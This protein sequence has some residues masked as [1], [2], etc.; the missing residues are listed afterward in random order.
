MTDDVDRQAIADHGDARHSSVEQRKHHRDDAKA[1]SEALEAEMKANADA[2]T[3]MAALLQRI[4]TAQE[5]ERARIARTLHDHVGQQLTALRLTLQS[6]E[7]R[8]KSGALDCEQLHQALSMTEKIDGDLDFLA[9]ELRPRALDDHGL[10]A[11]LPNFVREWS[12]H[13][14][15]PVEYRGDKLLPGMLSRDAETAFY[16][17]TQEALNN[18]LK[19]A[20]ASRVDV[21]VEA[22]GGCVRLVIEDNGVG[23]EP[24]EA[25]VSRDKGMGMVGMHERASLI[26]GTLQIESQ[27]GR[28]TA[29]Y[30]ESPAVNAAGGPVTT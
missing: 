14:A 24:A 27:P 21:L 11:A 17:V 26:G 23:F 2:R 30:L 13:Y 10:A 15:I 6:H 16:R 3:V 12:E 19:H 5:D 18:V 22:R 29:V 1:S 7:E 8:L 25:D 9:W 20:H 4:V 28:G